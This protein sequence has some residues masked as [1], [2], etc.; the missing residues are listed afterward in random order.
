MRKGARLHSSEKARGRR[1][2]GEE[3]KE[4]DWKI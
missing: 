2:K 3:I 4:R 1:I